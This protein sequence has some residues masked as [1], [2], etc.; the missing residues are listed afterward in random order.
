MRSVDIIA[1]LQR[2]E[3]TRNL[4]LDELE[5]LI[6]YVEI[7]EFSKDEMVFN[8]GDASRELYLVV[9]GKL[10]VLRKI[11]NRFEQFGLIS[12]G[13]FFGE[14][15]HLENEQRSA[16]VQAIEPVMALSIHLDKLQQKET[17]YSK[18]ITQLAKKVSG[19]LRKADQ[20]LIESLKEKL[21]FMQTHRLASDTIIHVIVLVA[22]WFNLYDLTTWFPTYRQ[23]LDVIVTVVLF[24]AFATSTFYVILTSGYPISFFGLTLKNWFRYSVEAI[25][26]S[27]PI[28]LFFGVLK[29]VLIHNVAIFDGQPFFAPAEKLKAVSGV[30]A[31]YVL[32]TPLQEFVA[33][34]GLQSSFRNFFQGPNRVIAAIVVSNLIFQMLH[35]T[36]E[37]W[38]AIGSLVCGFFWGI[39]FESQKSLVGVSISHALIGGWAFFI[40]DFDLLIN[41]FNASRG[42]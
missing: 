12:D 42:I 29:Y 5:A 23:T 24:L 6:P 7:V 27:L 19:N 11:E 30:M 3:L 14:M 41:I 35:T 13:Q 31:A 1:F 17:I 28:M 38:I 4:A 33:R 39:L 20:T 16:S 15:A 26:Y 36:K 37:P 18:I 34:G 10:A 22:V 25:L 9:K 32:L 21:R 40:L 2:N 8:E